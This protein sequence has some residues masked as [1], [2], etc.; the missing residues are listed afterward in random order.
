MPKR[1]NFLNPEG[2]SVLAAALKPWRGPSVV[3]FAAGNEDNSDDGAGPELLR[4]LRGR[5]EAVL[6][7]GGCVPENLLHLAV[8]TS[9][10]R[11][12]LID[13]AELGRKPGACALL[14]PEEAGGFSFSTHGM[15]LSALAKFLRLS[16]PDCAVG[17]LGIQPA[18]L[19]AGHKGLS[20]EVKTAVKMLAGLLVDDETAAA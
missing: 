17:F 6:L 15:P 5:T 4:L 14:L 13:A 3:L 7:D 9:P 20:P 2:D 18:A 1:K 16:L 10:K 8:K 11:V 19:K 12:L